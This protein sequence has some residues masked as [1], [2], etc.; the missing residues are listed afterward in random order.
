MTAIADIDA[1]RISRV[2]SA[3]TTC[4]DIGA[5]DVLPTLFS[6]KVLV[7]YSS[8]FGGSATE[9]PA[10]ALIQSWRELVPGFDATCHELG[11]I[12]VAPEDGGASARCSVYARHWFADEIWAVRGH[13]QFSLSR[14]RRWTVRAMRFELAEESGRRELVAMASQRASERANH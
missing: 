7:D 14:G 10:S 11:G 5:F 6:E 4:V 2:V 12:V 8:L 13:Y 3:I 9:L 1:A